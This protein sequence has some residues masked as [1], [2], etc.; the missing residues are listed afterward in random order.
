MQNKDKYDFYGLTIYLQ[1][2]NVS[3]NKPFKDEL[4]KRHTK[5]CTNHKDT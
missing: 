3:I 5:Y 4:K 1:L 2:L